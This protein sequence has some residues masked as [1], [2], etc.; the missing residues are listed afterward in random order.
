MT[1]LHSETLAS[2]LT[3]P[4][5]AEILPT[6]DSTNNELKRRLLAGERTDTLLLTETQTGGRGR[7][8]RSFYS[9]AGSGLYLSLALCSITRYDD[10]VLLTTMASAAVVR[11]IERLTPYRPQIKWVNDIYLNDRKIGGIL[12]EA[13]NTPDGAL[14][15]V[16]IGI[17]IN[18]APT[19]FP[20]E[21]RDVA[22]WLELAPL[23]REQ[24]AAEITAQLYAY[25]ATLPERG[26]LPFYRAH[27][28]VL[29]REIKVLTDPP[30]TATAVDVD[31]DGGL[32][33]ETADGTRRT[34]S[35]GEI[36]VRLH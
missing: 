23:S 4:V 21:L 27:S 33:V 8:G 2:F 34:L 25:C 10:A 3:V 35:T 22:G 18:V 20:E 26:Y 36:S 13:V 12:T 16:V 29:G 30:Y 5:K 31:A 6:V 32:I 1:K 14:A 17:G 15:G 24:L 11:A 9:P 19:A 7:L 28:L